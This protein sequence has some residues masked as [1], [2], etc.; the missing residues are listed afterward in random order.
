[1]KAMI[2]VADESDAEGMLEIYAPIVLET[3]I[4]FEAQS[5]TVAEFQGRIRASLERRLWLVCDAGGRIAGYAYATQFN[6]RD[7]YIWSVE[8]SVYV[9]PGFH[10]RGIGRA[11]YT[12]LF[13][14]LA[15]QGYCTAVARITLP[16]QSSVTLHEAMGF[17]PVGVNEG[18]GYKTGEWHDVGIWQ[19]DISPRPL[20]PQPPLPFTSLAGTPEWDNALAEGAALLKSRGA[21]VRP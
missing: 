2:R 18:I 16:N 15:A 20:Q 3:A 17:R 6:P 13:R 4:S 7:S 8:V 11:L 5:P 19:M 10:R 21:D 9:H 14:C 12:S 1:M